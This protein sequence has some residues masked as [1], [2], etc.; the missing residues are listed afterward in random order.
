M[1]YKSKR[2]EQM[3]GEEKEEETHIKDEKGKNGNNR[4]PRISS[5]KGKTSIL[6]EKRQRL[7]NRISRKNR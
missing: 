7:V 6:E 1:Y 2:C 4:G 5:G 3:I